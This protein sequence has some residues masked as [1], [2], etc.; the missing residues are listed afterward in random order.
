MSPSAGPVGNRES[1]NWWYHRKNIK[2]MPKLSQ[3]KD[4]THCN[5]SPSVASLIC[6]ILCRFL[7]NFRKFCWNGCC[8]VW[9]IFVTS[10]KIDEI[11]KEN[12]GIL[13][14]QFAPKG[15]RNVTDLH[16]RTL[17]CVAM[18]QGREQQLFDN[19]LLVFIDWFIN[20]DNIK[21]SL[22]VSLEIY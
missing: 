21:V 3:Q 7:L 11:V 18:R 4:G 16:N 12:V 20:S 10:I 13:N 15:I 8:M 14:W 6:S 17:T 19:C 1:P 9:G 2:M 22:L 5:W